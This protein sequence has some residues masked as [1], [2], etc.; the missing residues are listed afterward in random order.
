[1]TDHHSDAFVESRMRGNSPTL[2]LPFERQAANLIFALV[3]RRYER[4]SII[5]T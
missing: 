1:M 5:V 2:Y 3:S 4:G